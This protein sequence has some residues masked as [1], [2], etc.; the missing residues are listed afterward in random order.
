MPF[1]D[2]EPY[3]L[4]LVASATPVVMSS[5]DPNGRFAQFLRIVVRPS[6]LDGGLPFWVMGASVSVAVGTGESAGVIRITQGGRHKLTRV[7]RGSSS[8]FLRVP[9]A[10]GAGIGLHKLTKCDFDYN[11]DWIEIV[12]PDWAKRFS[13]GPEGKPLANVP[14]RTAATAPIAARSVR[15]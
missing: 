13:G 2:I 11:S 10:A 8:V 6:L 4:G 1:V 9:V 3:G 12:L 15:A 5:S 7:G 14:F